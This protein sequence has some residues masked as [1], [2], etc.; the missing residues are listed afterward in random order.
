MKKW[1][2]LTWKCEDYIL[3]QKKDEV[4]MI[5]TEDDFIMTLNQNKIKVVF[6]EYKDVLIK[7]LI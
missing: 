4:Y 2:G 5:K 3:I 7:E 6:G 1:S